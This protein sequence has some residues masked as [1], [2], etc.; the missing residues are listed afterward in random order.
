MKDHRFAA[1]HDDDRT[2]AHFAAGARGR[3]D[4]DARREAAPV[5]V[6]IKWNQRFV[7]SFDAQA[8]DLA[9]VQRAAAAEGDHRIAFVPGTQ[10]SPPPRLRWWDLGWTPEKTA[11]FSTGDILPRLERVGRQQSWIGNHQWPAESQRVQV[12]RQLPNAPAPNRILVGK[13]KFAI[14]FSG[15]FCFPR[16]IFVYQPVVQVRRHG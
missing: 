1:I 15:S 7:R 16:D 6:E 13:E 9:H 12:L 2:A 3:R 4:R 10:P 8:D 14:M 5:G 11:H